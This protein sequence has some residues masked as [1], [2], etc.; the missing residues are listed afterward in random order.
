MSSQQQLQS[1]SLDDECRKSEQQIEVLT[2]QL[3][4]LS[5]NTNSTMV[6]ASF[7]YRRRSSLDYSDVSG[8]DR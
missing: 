1:N 8:W 3:K 4:K 2:S 5:S 7:A 6:P